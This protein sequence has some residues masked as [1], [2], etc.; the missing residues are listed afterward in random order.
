M[1]ARTAHQHA[2]AVIREETER[3]L[4]ALAGVEDGRPVPGP[5][6]RDVAGLLR[7]VAQV[8]D[9][10]ARA[11]DGGAATDG[12]VTAAQ[13]GRAG[14]PPAGGDLRT[15]V[16]TAG[17]E[18]LA[19][20]VDRTPDAP[21][22]DVAALADGLAEHT[23]LHRVDAERAAGLPVR[24]PSVEVAERVLAVTVG[25]LRAPARDDVP[26][27]STATVRLE[28]ENTGTVHDVAVPCDGPRTTP[29]GTGGE[30]ADGAPALVVRGHAWDLL[31]WLN[32][33]AGAERVTLTG[34]ADLTITL[35]A[36]VESALDR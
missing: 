32:G 1:D 14:S 2:L 16:A 22:S 28:V 29:A 23:L 25:R 36:L 27:G 8:Q 17:T 6:G 26:D 11:V 12:G 18:L 3:L 15:W 7:H 4:V 24:P 31:L 35:L 30:A 10:A 9:A 19:A 5:A 21:G 13:P 33:R 34:D 20:L